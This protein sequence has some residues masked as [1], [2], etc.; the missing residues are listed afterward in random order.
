MFLAA[1]SLVAI[2]GRGLWGPAMGEQRPCGLSQNKSHPGS[3]SYFGGGPASRRGNAE[4]WLNMETKGR[5]TIVSD[6]SMSRNLPFI[7]ISKEPTYGPA[8]NA[9]VLNCGGY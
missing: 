2:F 6:G 4:C 7:S 8:Q 5:T 3:K 1:S 9:I